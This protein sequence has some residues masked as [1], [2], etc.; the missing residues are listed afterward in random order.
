MAAAGANGG[1]GA[2]E[3][4]IA[5][6][7]GTAPTIRVFKFN[8]DTGFGAEY[9]FTTNFGTQAIQ[10]SADG[11]TLFAITGFG[12]H[13]LRAYRWNKGVGFGTLYPNSPTIPSNIT[14]SFTIRVHPSGEAV[15]LAGFGSSGNTVHAYRFDPDTGWGTK[16]PEIALS[17]NQFDALQFSPSGDS[18]IAGGTPLTAM[19]F[20]LAT[21]AGAVLN[22]RTSGTGIAIMHP[23]GEFVTEALTAAPW[24]RTFAYS[25][26]AGFGSTLPNLNQTPSPSPAT[27]YRITSYSPDGTAI[28]GTIGTTTSP[29]IFRFT[30][31]HGMG[32]NIG[33]TGVASFFALWHPEADV[34]I[35]LSSSANNPRSPRAARMVNNLVS[36]LYPTIPWTDS[37]GQRAVH[38]TPLY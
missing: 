32:Q 33:V 34:L 2:N 35:A 4:D 24:S 31:T 26:A 29:V 16:Y 37:N 12:P 10:F 36:S 11:N 25:D 9:A 20:S 22:T 6:S 1:G 19:A 30:Q 21:G 27:F 5:F 15:L 38:F 18:F 8:L 3:F 23:S 17:G 14:S 7:Q 28:V 13:Q